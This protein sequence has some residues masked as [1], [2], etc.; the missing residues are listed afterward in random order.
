MNGKV[1]GRCRPIITVVQPTVDRGKAR[2]PDK[3][4][5]NLLEFVERRAAG[6]RMS[7][8]ASAFTGNPHK[9]VISLLT[10]I[11]VGF[12]LGIRHATD[13]DHV[14]AVSTIVTREQ[15]IGRS[16]LIGFAWGVGHTLTIL[17]VG[18]VLVVFRIT[19][20]PR[21][22]LSMELA[23]GIML[24]VLGIWN[25]RA[26]R[27]HSATARYHLHGDYIHVHGHDHHHPPEQTPLGKLDRLFPRSVIYSA[28]R[29]IIIGVV[30]G[31]AGSAAIALLVLSTIPSPR[32]AVAYLLIFGLG[33][34]LGMAVI[35]VAMASTV[36]YGQHRFARV[37]SHFDVA[38]GLISLAFGVFVTYQIGFTAG[39]FAHHP[40]WIP[41]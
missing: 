29:P 36:W 15:K 30:H 38:A 22:G 27:D 3:A 1:F 28:V 6:W 9:P 26:H 41:R 39:L 11:G 24:I 13:P 4:W 20:P 37:G 19:L 16:A 17:L 8:I 5:A 23:V 21:L 7:E 12:L 40:A 25:L 18:S 32:W 35:T 33:T 31:L 14:I 10:I 2:A 34:I